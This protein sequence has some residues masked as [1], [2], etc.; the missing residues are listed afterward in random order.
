MTLQERIFLQK[1]ADHDPSVASW[2]LQ[3][4]RRRHR[5]GPGDGL[6][7]FLDALNLGPS[8]PEETYRPDDDIEG[9]FGGAPGWLRRS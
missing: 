8:A 1:L 5:S 9:W 7:R 6:D 4:L 3:T 2:L